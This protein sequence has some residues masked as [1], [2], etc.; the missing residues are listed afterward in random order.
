VGV[1]Q[2]SQLCV[3]RKSYGKTQ[4]LAEGRH[5]D[6]ECRCDVRSRRQHRVPTLCKKRKGWATL[7]CFVQVSKGAPPAVQHPFRGGV[8][9][10]STPCAA[11]LKSLN[12][13]T[14][15]REHQK[16]TPHRAGIATLPG[17][18]SA[19]RSEPES[20]LDC[21]ATPSHCSIVPPIE[22]PA[23]TSWLPGAPSPIL[24]Q[25]KPELDQGRGT[26]CRSNSLVEF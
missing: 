18:E 6:S 5:E 8:S 21:T 10:P 14:A 25:L 4:S 1:E 22:R 7:I 3:W 11:R 20:T 17:Q 9:L 12:P 15:L 13:A 23:R 19:P 2:L 24:G 16:L 26:S